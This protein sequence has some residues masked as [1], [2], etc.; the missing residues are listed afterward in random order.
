MK[1]YPYA[2]G[3][4]VAWNISVYETIYGAHSNIGLEQYF[5]GLL[6]IKDATSRIEESSQL[7]EV[8]IT[9]FRY[10]INTLENILT[11]VSIDRTWARRRL[12]E[13]VGR[14]NYHWD[15][16]TIV[17]RNDNLRDIFERATKITQTYN[18]SS[19]HAIHMME[20]LLESPTPAILTLLAELKVN[21]SDL[22]NLVQQENVSNPSLTPPPINGDQKNNITNT[23][24]ENNDVL[25]ALGRDLTAMAMS[26]KLDS[27][28]GRDDELLQITRTL[29]RKTKSNP[30]LVGDAGV[31]KTAIVEGLAVRIANKDITKSLWGHRIVELRMSSLIA[32]TKF[33]G[34][35]EERLNRIIET[36]ENDKKLI[37]F[38]DELHTLVSAGDGGADVANILKPALARG[39][40]RCIGS[41]T[42]NEFQRYIENDPAFARRFIRVQINEP[43]ESEAIEILHGLRTSFEKHHQVNIDKNA[44]VS[45][46]KFSIRY[47]KDRNLPDK[48]IDLLDEAC[49]MVKVQTLSYKDISDD[50]ISTTNLSKQDYE[51][52]TSS[53]VAEVVAERTGIEVTELLDKGTE[54]F[55]QLEKHLYE[56][57][58]G[59]DAAVNTVADR[60]R[61]AAV[62]LRDEHKPVGVF[63]FLGPTGVGKTFLAESIA[64][65]L[66][67]SDQYLIRID[68]SEFM[69]RHTVARLIG[70]PPGYIGHD[71]EGQ[72]TGALKKRP[73]SLVLLDEI[74][75][76][77]PQ[78]WDLFLQVFDDG[79]LTDG[80][81]RTI[82]ASHAIFVM[83]TNIGVNH[84]A[85]RTV[86][87]INNIKD[88]TIEK[89]RERY[90]AEIRNSF[91]PEF[92][93]RIDDIV[94]F[95]SL[96]KQN[97]ESIAKR[98]IENIKN[99]L[100]LRNIGLEVQNDVFE[101]L[102][103]EGFSSDYGA[104]HMHRTIETLIGKPLSEYL[105]Q[106]NT[107]E[108]QQ[109]TIV[110]NDNIIVVSSE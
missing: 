20:A 41:T 66:F 52:V 64:D 10:E 18:A 99:K 85:K 71:E 13:I 90:L 15:K 78:I 28:I 47:I 69:E 36:V 38:L 40:I 4:L 72:L 87:F 73:Y 16:E 63:L 3:T 35:M 105:L 75:K 32:G 82:D 92:L 97:I 48:A 102:I 34:D 31:G 51:S 107:K 37:L 76:A 88:G 100:E 8:D 7:S 44:I 19:V 11:Q 9:L 104:R 110:L 58:I 77:H 74:E 65:K 86:G 2:P 17:H 60:L 89:E 26:G 57:V 101:L 61:L 14:G 106:A 43:S 25:S 98:E 103:N 94:I 80:K 91:R 29:T 96:T 27:V 1:K 81:N 95:N 39:T 93:N 108:R 62:G 6:K 109:L 56:K 83:T 33:R 30:V 5:C 24:H 84:D 22:S 67:G 21:I 23:V 45:A 12:R 54:K 59:Q 70:S 49:A 79:R 53:V 46:V 50:T 68:M 55:Q 42:F